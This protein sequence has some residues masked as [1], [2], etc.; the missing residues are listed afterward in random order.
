[1]DLCIVSPAHIDRAWREG[2]DQ[3]EIALERCGDECTASQLKL[4]LARGEKTLLALV[5]DIPTAWAAVEFMNLP[6]MRVLHI[7]AIYA[8]GNAVQATFE[9][10]EAYA[11][12]GGASSIQGACDPVISRLWQSKFDFKEQYRVMRKAL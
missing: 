1:M 8:P 2:A 3:L 5:G 6:N 7:Y 4:M 10:L 11:K 9:K 12:D